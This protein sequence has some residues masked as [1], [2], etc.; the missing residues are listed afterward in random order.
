[1]LKQGRTPIVIQVTQGR[2]IGPRDSDLFAEVFEQFG[3][4]TLEC[5]ERSATHREKSNGA[6]NLRFEREESGYLKFRQFGG[7]MPPTQ[8]GDMPGQHDTLRLAR[9]ILSMQRFRFR[10]RSL[11]PLCSAENATIDIKC[12][13][14]PE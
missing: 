7:K 5:L 4:H 1:M 3:R 13:G 9:R 2:D 6:M 14:R 11:I 12:T 10:W 8:I